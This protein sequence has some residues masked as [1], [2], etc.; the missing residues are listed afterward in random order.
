MARETNAAD[1]VAQARSVDLPTTTASVKRDDKII[2]P[3]DGPVSSDFLDELKFMEEPVDVMVHESA[4]DN[5]EAIVE[6]FHNGIP[7][8]FI[9]GQTQTV[10]RKF[11]EVL[12]RA[13]KTAYSQQVFA[14]RATGDAIQ[15][16]TPHTALQYPFQVVSDPNPRGTPWLRKVL[17]EAT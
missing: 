11:I 8:R 10:K 13:K 7:Q 15:R 1:H 6:V 5:A 3:V 9:R 16:M 2:E 14:D 12:A 4:A 17:A